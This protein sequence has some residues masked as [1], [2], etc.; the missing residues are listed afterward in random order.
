MARRRGPG[1]SPHLQ[2]DPQSSGND[3]AWDLEIAKHDP[4]PQTP[5]MNDE[6][7]WTTS[8]AAEI[9]LAQQQQRTSDGSLSSGLRL[10]GYSRCS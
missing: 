2:H 6:Y 5:A 9:P 7:T 1:T 4:V 3:N 8:Q 10:E